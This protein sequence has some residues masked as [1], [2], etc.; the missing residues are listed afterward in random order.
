MYAPR[1]LM[2]LGFSPALPPL[3]AFGGHPLAQPHP[4]TL[5]PTGQPGLGELR[6]LEGD[7]GSHWREG[8][9]RAQPSQPC[10]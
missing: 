2:C 5:F 3:G 8:E 1:P 9:R 10:R 6:A 7:C 4:S